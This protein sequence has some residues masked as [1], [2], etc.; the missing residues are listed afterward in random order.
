MMASKTRHYNWSVKLIDD[1]DDQID[2]IFDYVDRA[3]TDGRF[4]EVNERVATLEPEQLG[5][6]SISWLTALNWARSK[7][8]NYNLYRDKVVRY[9]EQQGQSSRRLLQG[10]L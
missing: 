1:I 10:L 9:Y 2:E 7:I 3:F 4:A 6:A 8:P 5:E